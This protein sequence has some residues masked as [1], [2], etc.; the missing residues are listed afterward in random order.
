MAKKLG[1]RRA[2][3]RSGFG[4]RLTSRFLVVLLTAGALFGAAVASP[5]AAATCTDGAITI[6]AH[7]DDDLLFLNPDIMHDIE[8]GRCA[9]TVFV[10]AG[11]SGDDQSYWG[12]LEA[13]I[14]ATYA[15][16]AGVANRWTAADAGIPAGAISIHTLTAAPHVSVVFLRI[17]D[18]FDG[19][20]SAAY[21]WQSLAKLWD[22]EISTVTTVD[23]REWYTKT[24]VRDILVKLMSD[25][26]ATTVRT[27]DWTSDPSNLDD[28]SD[29]WAT[30]MFT[31]LA[32]RRYTAAHT[33]LA[34]EGYPTW[35]YDENVTGD[36]LTKNID[37]FV[38]F[39]AYDHRLCNSPLEG[40]PD[41]PHDLWLERQYVVTVESTKNAAR[42][43]GVTVAV[44]TSK[45][46]AQGAAKAKDGYPGGAPMNPAQEWVTNGEKAGG[47]IQYS[48]AS[49]T[50]LDGVTLFDRPNLA[51][52]VVG[53]NIVFSDGSSVPVAALPNNGSGLTIRFPA[54]T[55]TSVRLN[56]TAVSGTTTDVG[57][58]E[59]EAWRGPA[60]TTAPVVTASP[61]GGKYPAGQAIT[62][63][64][65][66]T[67]KIY[68]TTNGTTPSASSTLYTGPIT[69]T[70]GFTLRY[71]GVDT[72]G[73]ASAPA[74]QVYTVATAD[75]TAP[76]VTA[77]PVGGKYPAG[78]A[79][80]LSAN[81][82]AKI[83]Y[84]TNGTTPSAS[85]TLYTGPIT[86]TT[87]FTLRYLGVDTAGNASA[88]AQQVYTV[89]TADTTAP[90]VTASPVGG[91][92]PA[93]QAITLSA[94][95]TA[96]IYYT[97][98]GTTPSASS[99]LYTGP[100]TLT[101]GFTLRYLG[102]D[103]AG[104]ASA[105]AQQVYTV[106]T[107]DTTAPVV[108]ASPV[109]GKYPA[110]QAITLSA[111]ETAKIY[112]TTNGTT[113]SASST[114]YTGP[115]TL[116]TGFTLRYLGVDTAGNASAP[117]QQVYTVATAD[118][119][120]PVVT[121]SPVGGS[122]P[123]GQQI[124]L[125][126]NETAKI[127]YTVNGSA[128]TVSS[129]VYSAPLT[130]NAPFQLRYFA[131]DTAGNQSGAGSQ[132]YAV[133]APAIGPS[134]DFD[135]DGKAD[136]LARDQSG[137]L[138]LQPGNGAGGWLTARVVGTGWNVMTAIFIPGDFDGDGNVDVLARDTG[139]RLIL[140]PGN[141]S[142]GWRTPVQVGSGWT[143][144][145]SI[146]GP[147]DFDGDGNVD[148]LAVDGGYRML[149]YPGD[150]GGGWLD[151]V[152]VGSGWADMT[153]VVAPGDFNGDGAVDVMA[154][155]SGGTLYL[156][157]GDGGG[158]WL[159][160]LQVGTGWNAMTAIIGPGDFNGDGFTDLLARNSTG[161][162][163]LYPGDGAGGWKPSTQVGTGWNG[164]TAIT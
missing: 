51:D 97:T 67:A 132:S 139:G 56:I 164:Y 10:T 52:Q 28:H 88:P 24:E 131:V 96:K 144:M 68:Y 104:N 94:N 20:G 31:Q 125:S 49:P 3:S 48:F 4:R 152:Q 158:G 129:P 92:Y 109:G 163:T 91:K 21:G 29:H 85:S 13:G 30:A 100:I 146:I 121:A 58:G 79:I 6:V 124:S 118:T 130:L 83:Y 61:V 5:A 82:T 99:T 122:Y 36:D 19:S 59:F 157:P 76:V 106:A 136:V 70:T 73:N 45:S 64:A 161:A 22:G 138:W 105:P 15:E 66:E 119:T 93:G 135:G 47:W 72:A 117:A 101:T 12:S 63:S 153:A 43:S 137:N 120:A 37:A 110:G 78:Q 23:G 42:E 18:G 57:L 44:S 54:R 155:T 86:L 160:R 127:H 14:R 74:Q 39:A 55:V 77:S 162:L 114:L 9:R 81:E 46:T 103:T 33:L 143:I 75:T 41:Y 126:A 108:T 149:L 145:R 134:H 27:Q 148:V 65:N 113:P 116:T 141:G 40:C 151:P 154:R 142:G 32:S 38:T 95:E 87:G 17:P 89:A 98:N 71:L 60:D 107:A 102:V 11:E 156:Y 80:T 150:G 123:A 111:N 25:F 7:T 1:D 140:Y 62:L 16:M 35:T 128:P 50:P 133:R 26:K 112:Y 90:V 34:Y 84:T 69:L 147:G 115:I 8:A 2:R 159:P 53:A